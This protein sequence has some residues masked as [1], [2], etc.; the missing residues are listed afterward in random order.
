M[1]YFRFYILATLIL[2]F[3]YTAEFKICLKNIER[4]FHKFTK[5]S[6]WISPVAKRNLGASERSLD[7]SKTSVGISKQSLDISKRNLGRSE[8]RSF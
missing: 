7:L 2:G 5:E 8:Q 1:I 3:K 6:V 4:L